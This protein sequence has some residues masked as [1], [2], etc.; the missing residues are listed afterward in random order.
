MLKISHLTFSY[1]RHPA[2]SGGG[3]TSVLRDVSFTLEA[4]RCLVVAGAN[5]CGKSTLL[6]LL[7]GALS[8]ADGSVRTDGETIG[9]VPQGFAVFD[10]MTVLDNIRFFAHL[11]HKEV[12]RPLSFGLEPYAKKKAALLSGGYKKRLCIACTAA[13]DPDIWLF[14]E[15]CANLDIVWRDEMIRMVCALKDAG[16]GIVYVGHDPAEFVPF[17]DEILFLNREGSCVVPR[18]QIA[19]GTE[20][21]LIRSRI[22]G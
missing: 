2:L 12:S 17:Y 8:G 13:A 18:E 9:L 1:R 21:D 19:P 6:A 11:Q 15:P 16:K 22:N 3:R 5:G 20:A 7:S 14:D 10:D 4:G